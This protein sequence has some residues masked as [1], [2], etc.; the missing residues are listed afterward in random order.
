MT[1]LRWL[2]TLIQTQQIAKAKEEKRRKVKVE[3]EG[4][5]VEIDT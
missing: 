4:K 2:G 1:Q 3:E 5:I